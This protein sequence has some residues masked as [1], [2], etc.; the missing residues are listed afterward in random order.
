MILS[1]WARQKEAIPNRGTIN[2]EA[3]LVHSLGFVLS[4]GQKAVPSFYDCS[5]SRNHAHKITAQH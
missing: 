2:Y 1:C 4:N 3:I 5:F